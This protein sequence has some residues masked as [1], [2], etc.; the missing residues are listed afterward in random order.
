MKRQ[1]ISYETIFN[2]SRI[3]FRMNVLLPEL[4]ENVYGIEKKM[5]KKTI[6]SVC[7]IMGHDQILIYFNVFVTGQG[8]NYIFFS[9]GKFI[10]CQKNQAST[11]CYYYN[12]FFREIVWFESM[13]IILL[14]SLELMKK[15]DRLF[16]ELR[17]RTISNNVYWWEWRKFRK[18]LAHGTF[19]CSYD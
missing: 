5:K 15:L 14:F 9:Y 13:S 17:L 12:S 16:L 1:I 2:E 3:F 8:Q 6:R 4:K 7:I 19:F 18:T 11:C 10:T